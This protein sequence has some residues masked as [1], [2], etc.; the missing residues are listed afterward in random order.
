M[1]TSDCVIVYVQAL[2]IVLDYN[3]LCQIVNVQAPQLLLD[4]DLQLSPIDDRDTSSCGGTLTN[5]QIGTKGTI[6]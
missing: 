3:L 2:Q 1:T 4:D 6:R 5:L